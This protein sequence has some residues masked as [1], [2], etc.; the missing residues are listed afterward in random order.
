MLSLL[1]PVVAGLAILLGFLV[2]VWI[3]YSPIIGRIFEETPVFA[4]LRVPPEPGGEEVRFRTADGFELAGTYFPALTDNRTGVIVFC[5]EFLGDRWSALPYAEGLREAGFDL[6][7]FDFRNHGESQTDP[8]YSPLQWV[9]DRELVDLRAALDYLR[10]RP[11]R[12]PAGVGLFGVSRG[13]GTA[14]VAAASDPT[15]WAVATDGAFPTRGTML[16]YILRWAE[17][18]VGSKTIWRRMPKWMFASAG[19]A[20]RI[21]SQWLL[22]RSYPSLERAVARLAPRPWLMIHG[23]KDAYIGPEIALE[24]F[25][26]ADDPKEAWIVPGAKHN[27]CREADPASYRDR[28]VDFFG[29]YA[30]RRPVPRPASAPMAADLVVASQAPVAAA[31]AIAEPVT[32]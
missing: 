5:P 18:Y 4:P 20:G 25:D 15:I 17:I 21:R 3:R 19:W 1:I 27:R 32:R 23:E 11:D 31:R 13:G 6:F 24:L 30:P 16:A 12:D 9:S 10:G 29:R 14:L 8:S 26:R 7:T 22:G 28:L 2:Y